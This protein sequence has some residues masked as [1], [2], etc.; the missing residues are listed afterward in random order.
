MRRG[1]A[2]NTGTL[3]ASSRTNQSDLDGVAKLNSEKSKNNLAHV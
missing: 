2:N 1:I 3:N